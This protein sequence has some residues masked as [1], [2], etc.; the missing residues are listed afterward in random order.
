MIWN[1]EECHAWHRFEHALHFL[2]GRSPT[3]AAKMDYS[4]PL[5]NKYHEEEY[6]SKISLTPPTGMVDGNASRKYGSI[7]ARGSLNYSICGDRSLWEQ[8]RQYS[9]RS[10]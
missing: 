4:T 5:T 2:D 3:D 9:K 8:Y 1:G 10:L 7:T 6:I